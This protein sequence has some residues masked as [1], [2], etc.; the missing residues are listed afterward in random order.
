VG[1]S[2][3]TYLISLGLGLQH[4]TL[5]SVA[6]SDSLLT[7]TVRATSDAINP[8]TPKGIASLREI[9]GVSLVLPKV[10]TKGTISLEN[11]QI[12]VTVNGVDGEY[13]GGSDDTK[14]LVGRAY[15]SGD[16]GTMVVTTRLLELFGLDATR[17]PLVTLGLQLDQEVYPN[18]PGLPALTVSGVVQSNTVAIF[19]PRA[20]LEGLTGEAQV[21]D[22]ARLRVAD[23]NQIESV[24]KE[25]VKHGYQVD[26]VID[27]VQEIERVF[28][29]VRIV[30][31]TLGLIAVGV[32]SIGMFNTLTISLLERTKEIGVMK[33][34]GVRRNDIRRL[35]LCEALLMGLLG[36]ILGLLGGVVGQQITYFGFNVLASF[37]QG[38]VPQLFVNDPLIFAG[39]LGLALL[40][41]MITGVYPAERA[42]RI[43]PID[44]I[45]YQ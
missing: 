43:N 12:P 25:V 38:K 24:S 18:V 28:K 8:L 11:K 4:L 3:M 23:L 21:Y 10:V 2:V 1:I 22:N 16:K 9:S 45:R 19:L 26:A 44:A 30:L 20:Y 5:D 6:Q 27:T 37:L 33:A 13:F 34:L 29:W 42:T 15:R 39:F 17:V 36:G 31:G 35:F 40:V 7:M 41:A 14:I 32:A